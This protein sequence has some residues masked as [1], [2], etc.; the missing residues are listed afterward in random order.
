MQ[1]LAAQDCCVPSLSVSRSGIVHAV[2]AYGHGKGHLGLDLHTSHPRSDSLF[3]LRICNPEIRALT[4]SCR[5]H[6]SHA[7]TGQSPNG[8]AAR[9]PSLLWSSWKCCKEGAR[10]LSALHV[11][12]PFSQVEYGNMQW[13]GGSR[14]GLGGLNGAK[15]GQLW[16]FLGSW[17]SKLEIWAQVGTVPL[18]LSLGHNVWLMA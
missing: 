2:L 12:Q 1:H 11:C 7:R 5:D 17:A 16:P 4:V 8:S 18:P 9:R 15:W 14:G 3:Q 10:A 13:G 6:H